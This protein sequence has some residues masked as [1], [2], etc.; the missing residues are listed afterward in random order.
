MGLGKWV[1]R[2]DPK[3]ERA[4]D[5][6]ASLPDAA[7]RGR[8][9]VPFP[10][11]DDAGRKAAF[12]NQQV[13]A[14]I[15]AAPIESV[16]LAKLRSAQRSV[17]PL[18]VAAYVLHP[19]DKPRRAPSGVPVDVPIAVLYEGRLVLIDG[20]HRSTARWALGHKTVRARVADLDALKE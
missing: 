1:E 13:K 2:K 15:E 17:D 3:I 5:R 6:I 11:A 12:T 8:V 16:P 14:A 10:W 19:G 4:M 7:K 20:N 9:D 18:Q